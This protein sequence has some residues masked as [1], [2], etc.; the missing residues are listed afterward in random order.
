MVDLKYQ[1]SADHFKIG[2]FGDKHVKRINIALVVIGAIT[3]LTIIFYIIM[4][5]FTNFNAL[6]NLQEYQETYTEEDDMELRSVNFAAKIMPSYNAEKNAIWMNRTNDV[7]LL[8]TLIITILCLL[9]FTYDYSG[10]RIS[11]P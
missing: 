8:T 3:L 2:H 11:N 5:S 9:T 4:Y 6:D 10:I 7:R 1:L